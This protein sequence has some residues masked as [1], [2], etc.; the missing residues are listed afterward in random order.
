[1]SPLLNKINNA[2]CEKWEKTTSVVIEV[3]IEE[4]QKTAIEEVS[5]KKRSGCNKGDWL[6]AWM[7]VG[8][9]RSKREHV[10]FLKPQN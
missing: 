7:T 6:I 3:A 4:E 10:C 8:G 9:E 1:M 2:T 5:R